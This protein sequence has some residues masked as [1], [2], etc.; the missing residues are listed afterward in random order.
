MQQFDVGVVGY[1]WAANAI[2]TAI[3][4]GGHGRVVGVCSSRQ[5]DAEELSARHGTPIKTYTDYAAM[6]FPHIVPSINRIG[7]ALGVHAGPGALVVALRIESS[8]R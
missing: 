1:G 8:S 2:I 5:L 6:L 3:N 7:P 4:T